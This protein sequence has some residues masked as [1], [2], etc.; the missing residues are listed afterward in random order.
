MAS[1]AKAGV[2]TYFRRRNTSNEWENITDIYSISGP[3]LSKDVIDVTSFNS[4]NGYREFIAGFKNSGS[5]NL[6]LNFTRRTYALLLADFESN[7]LRSYCIDLPDLSDTSIQFNGIV[8]E[9]PMTI[10]ADDKISFDTTIKVTG[11][12]LIYTRSSSDESSSS[13]SMI[14]YLLYTDGVTL[15]RKGVRNYSFVVDIALTGTG[16]NGTEGVDW[17]NI[18]IVN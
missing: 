6:K 13:G 11:G 9:L 1:N 3:R 10:P 16:F 18:Q 8:I 17:E 7:N 2:G 12:I 15:I 5:V 14:Q 4:V